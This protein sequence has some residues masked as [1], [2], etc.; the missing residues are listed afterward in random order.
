MS[1]MILVLI[2]L[3][4]SSLCCSCSGGPERVIAGA[5]QLSSPRAWGKVPRTH[6]TERLDSSKV[7]LPPSDIKKVPFNR[8]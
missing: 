8:P 3:L 2:V 6:E 4:R 7:P 5:P 1:A